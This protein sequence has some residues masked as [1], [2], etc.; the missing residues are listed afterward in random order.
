MRWDFVWGK[1][2]RNY[3]EEVIKSYICG[4]A[5]KRSG[6][7]QLTPRALARLHKGGFENFKNKTL[8]PF[9]KTVTAIFNNGMFRC[10]HVLYY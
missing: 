7:S 9:G 4:E 8:S 5:M 3:S 6:N 2:S 1:D 10:M